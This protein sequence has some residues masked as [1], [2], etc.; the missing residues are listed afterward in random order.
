LEKY[1]PH[2]D[3][4]KIVWKKVCICKN[5]VVGGI[6]SMIC[7]TKHHFSC[8]NM[9]KEINKW[10]CKSCMQITRTETVERCEIAKCVVW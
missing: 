7:I 1:A 3:K 2:L 4:K 8:T 5:K 6:T 9:N 10:I